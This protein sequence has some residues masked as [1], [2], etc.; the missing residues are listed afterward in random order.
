MTIILKQ[1]E[2]VLGKHRHPNQPKQKP[3]NARTTCKFYS[4]IMHTIEGWACFK[5]FSIV[6][7]LNTLSLNAGKH[8]H[9]TAQGKHKIVF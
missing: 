2:I 8:V 3:D 1:M 4:P 7:S 9:H 5:T 6:Q